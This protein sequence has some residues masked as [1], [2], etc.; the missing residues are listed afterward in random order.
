M[1]T[2]SEPSSSSGRYGTRQSEQSPT[3]SHRRVQ[4]TPASPREASG[5]Q[6]TSHGSVKRKN[7]SSLD[8]EID[9]IDPREKRVCKGDKSQTPYTFEE[10]YQFS[11]SK[12]AKDK[13]TAIKMWRSGLV[14]W[15][16][17]A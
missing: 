13:S 5:G 2:K 11:V 14:H 16:S 17:D 12:G 7:M 15:S 10:M 1:L 9:A 6:S 3:A 4:L 8:Q